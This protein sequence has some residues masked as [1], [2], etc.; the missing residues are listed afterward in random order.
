MP[1]S[2]LSIPSFLVLICIIFDPTVCF[3]LISEG[4]KIVRSSPPTMLWTLREPVTL[5][6]QIQIQLIYI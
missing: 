5:W 3:E 1:F 6:L 4:D 2:P